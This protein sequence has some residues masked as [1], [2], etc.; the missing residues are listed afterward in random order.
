MPCLCPWVLPCPFENVCFYRHNNTPF[1]LHMPW[2][3]TGP[4]ASSLAAPQM[5]KVLS[6]KEGAWPARVGGPPAPSKGHLLVVFF[7]LLLWIEVGAD[8]NLTTRL[9]RIPLLTSG[10]RSRYCVAPISSLNTI[11]QRCCCWRAGP[12]RAAQPPQ[13]LPPASSA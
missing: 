13:P 4:K 1:S 7:P 8:S 6:G 11:P 12:S 5:H 2:H 9:I 10:Q 3:Q